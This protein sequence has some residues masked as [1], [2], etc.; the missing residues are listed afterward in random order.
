M[1]ESFCKLCNAALLKESEEL[2]EVCQKMEGRLNYLI[3]IHREA[4]KGYLGKKL[5]ETS[6]PKMQVYERRAQEYTPPKGGAVGY[7]ISEHSEHQQRSLFLLW[8]VA[9]MGAVAGYLD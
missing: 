8:P 3:E 7:D 1:T 2:C 4:A 9:V 5:N 6:D